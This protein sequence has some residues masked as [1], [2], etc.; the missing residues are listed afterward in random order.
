M[1]VHRLQSDLSSLGRNPNDV[2]VS[3][4]PPDCSGIAVACDFK[5]RLVP[6]SAW[7]I[8]GETWARVSAYNWPIIGNA[9]GGLSHGD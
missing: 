1:E 2:P 8:P 3:Q 4:F 5:G 9:E 6:C 7:E